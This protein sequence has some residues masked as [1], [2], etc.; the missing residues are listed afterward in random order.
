[1]ATGHA[2]FLF[3]IS[4]LEEDLLEGRQGALYHLLGDAVAQAEVARHTE[5]VGGDDEQVFLLGDL[6]EGHRVPAGGLDEE[7]ESALGLGALVADFGQTIVEQVAVDVVGFEVGHDVAA[8]GNGALDER[9]GAD[10]AQHTGSARDGGKDGLGIRHVV[11]HE[12]VSDTLARQAEG[13]G[14][15]VADD[16]VLVDVG[17][18]GN[19]NSIVDQLPVGFVG[20]DVDGV[21]VLLS[22]C[23]KNV[24]NL[25]EGLSAED[26]AGGV[27]GGVYDDGLGVLIHEGFERGKV[28]LEALGVSRDHDELV[29]GGFNEGLVLRE[30]GGDG[31]DLA[32][33]AGEGRERRH[34]RRGSAAGKEEVRGADLLAEALGEVFGHGGADA[35][36]A[37]AA[38]VAVNLDA[39]LGVEYLMDAAIDFFGRRDGG[40]AE[41]VVKDVLLADDLGLLPAILEHL[42][43]IG[44]DASQSICCLVDHAEFLLEYCDISCR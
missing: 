21:A 3:S 23:S 13:L 15:G 42:A 27:V 11:G 10:V 19:L 31:N 22:C 35:V 30:E 4:A 26:N 1:M 41:A 29:A 40:V 12:D 16:G 34:E 18:K 43:D 24:R 39:A 5:G 44:A 17:D 7:I 9:G 25:A 8:L 36:V 28:Y 32:V 14:P 38:G 33:L 20:D 37:R 2:G 6:S